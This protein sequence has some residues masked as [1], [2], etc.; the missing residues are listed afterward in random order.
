MVSVPG[1]PH[2]A[3]TPNLGPSVP[4]RLLSIPGFPHNASTPNLGPP[5]PTRLKS[6]PGSPPK[7]ATPTLQSPMIPTSSWTPAVQA[8]GVEN[9]IARRQ[10]AEAR[11]SELE[12]LVERL[13]KEIAMLSNAA[14]NQGRGHPDGEHAANDKGY[15]D[16][17]GTDDPI[18]Q[19]INTYLDSNPDFPVSVRKVAPNHYVFGD[20]GNVYVTQRG[21]QIIVRV[22][23]G[24]K[25]LKAFM[26]ERALMVARDGAR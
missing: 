20:R 2:N 1:F 22:G 13:Q 21:E 5:S 7:S 9:E 25:S 24:F 18:D 12:A 6:I 19:A 3:S 23:G 14:N 8:D 26:D 16:T 17:L 11:V 10:A 4:S 15:V